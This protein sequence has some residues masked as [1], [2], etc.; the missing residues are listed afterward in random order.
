MVSRTFELFFLSANLYSGMNA[1]LISAATSSDSISSIETVSGMQIAS[2][3]GA[4]ISL[5][6]NS[7]GSAR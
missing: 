3:L 5:L 1:S 2:Q 6:P 7:L 4:Y